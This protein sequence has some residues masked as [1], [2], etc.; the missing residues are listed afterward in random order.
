M[1]IYSVPCLSVHVYPNRRVEPT[2]S[3]IL[4]GFV[5]VTL[6]A[7]LAFLLRLAHVSFFMHME[8]KSKETGRSGINHSD[9][10]NG[11]GEQLLMQLLFKFRGFKWSVLKC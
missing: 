9:G 8:K 4:T 10:L 7:E 5:F 2:L 6:I 3:S 11:T 1:N